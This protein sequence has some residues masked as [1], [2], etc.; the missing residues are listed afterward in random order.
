MP[1]HKALH[2]GKSH[3]PTLNQ[4]LPINMSFANAPRKNKNC[5]KFERKI[6]EI[7]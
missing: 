4:N 6:Y 3:E 7:N 2:I 1:T 5:S